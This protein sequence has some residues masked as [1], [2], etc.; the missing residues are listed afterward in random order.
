MSDSLRTHGVYSPWNSQGQNTAVGSLSFL[1]G[2]FPTQGSN[3]GLPHCRQVL[4]QLSH[5]G[6]PLSSQRVPEISSLDSKLSLLSAFMSSSLLPQDP[7]TYWSLCLDIQMAF[8]YFLQVSV[9]NPLRREAFP[10]L[11]G[12][13]KQKA[14]PRGELRAQ[15]LLG[16][17]LWLAS[18]RNRNF[19]GRR[20]GHACIHQVLHPRR[21]SQVLW[22]TL[23]VYG[24]EVVFSQENYLEDWRFLELNWDFGR[25]IMEIKKGD[26]WQR[27][28]SGFVS[29]RVWETFRV[30][31][32]WEMPEG[33][34]HCLPGWNVLIFCVH[35]EELCKNGTSGKDSRDNWVLVLCVTQEEIEASVY[36]ST[37][38]PTSGN[39]G[40]GKIWEIGK[41]L[42]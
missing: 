25:K 1:Q 17:P 22:W 9:K 2:V 7:F 14:A 3:P 34:G 28:T 20:W 12:T 37:K 30:L 39:C 42:W 38:W 24:R 10:G 13:E 36:T 8:L 4:Y 31:Q 27:S 5:K 32:G 26:S 15:L 21:P 40:R 19:A 6:S 18:L 11:H 33:R 29:G 16:F 41:L 23:T 35:A